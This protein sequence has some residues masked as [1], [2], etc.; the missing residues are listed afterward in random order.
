MTSANPAAGPVAWRA[1]TVEPI[2]DC[3]PHTWCVTGLTGISCP[4]ARLCVAVDN[5]GNAAR[6]TDPGSATPW[7]FTSFAQT[8]PVPFG[9]ISCPL[10]SRC[11]AVDGS[12]NS[13]ITTHPSTGSPWAVTNIEP[14]ANATLNAVSCFSVVFCV[15]VDTRGAA[16]LGTLSRGRILAS[17]SSLLARM[18]HRAGGAL[19]TRGTLTLSLT[20]PSP[21]RLALA[22]RVAASSV[23]GPASGAWIAVAALR[24]RDTTGGAIQLTLTRTGRRILSHAARL[25]VLARAT[26]TPSGSAPVSAI[27]T[28]TLSR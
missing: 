28:F 21:G 9:G 8:G 26:F 19:F 25:R 20:P 5:V 7:F 1:L 6:S 4:S 18:R 24:F 14:A 10:P 27:S 15:A 17:L 2:N 12:G 3:T 22:L 23:S 11:V 13:E 16:I